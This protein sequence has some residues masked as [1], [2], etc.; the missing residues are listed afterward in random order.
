[1]FGDASTDNN[2]SRERREQRDAL[3]GASARERH[4][5][6]QMQRYGATQNKRPDADRGPH[7]SNGV[8]LFQSK[9]PLCAQPSRSGAGRRERWPLA[10]R[11]GLPTSSSR[12]RE[13][14]EVV[15]ECDMTGD[16]AVASMIIK[17]TETQRHGSS[18]GAASATPTP[19]GYAHGV[20]LTKSGALL[21]MPQPNMSTKNTASTTPATAAPQTSR[22]SAAS[23][24]SPL[25]VLNRRSASAAANAPRIRRRPAQSSTPAVRAAPA[26]HG[27]TPPSRRRYR[28]HARPMQ[29]FAW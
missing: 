13:R 14:A 25:P 20:A 15:D 1:M 28:Q 5:C 21:N 24:D 16:H 12:R 8:G 22:V 2:I 9:V 10:S 26:P 3:R 27:T 6:F 11:R 18:G 4:R 29:N 7:I 23:G 17:D 19:S